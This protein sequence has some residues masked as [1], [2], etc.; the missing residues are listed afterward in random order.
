MASSEGQVSDGQKSR[1]RNNRRQGK[2]MS[3]DT[4]G[5]ADTH[6]KV[7]EKEIYIEGEENCQM[8]KG[9]TKR[10]R[11]KK[12]PLTFDSKSQRYQKI[13]KTRFHS[14]N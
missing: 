11:T 13:G 12:G 3:T 5:K 7:K 8:L 14:P 4:G 1:T 9:K 6:V 2:K 10:T